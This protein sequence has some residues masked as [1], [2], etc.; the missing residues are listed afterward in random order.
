MLLLHH[1]RIKECAWTHPGSNWRPCACEAHVI[2]N[3]TMSPGLGRLME[4]QPTK[5]P[6]IKGNAL[7]TAQQRRLRPR[8]EQAGTVRCVRLSPHWAREIEQR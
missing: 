6:H 8:L 2:T 5:T 1:G 7:K 3:Y 4:K